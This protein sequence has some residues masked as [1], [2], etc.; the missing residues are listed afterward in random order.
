MLIIYGIMHIFGV[1]I[2][3]RHRGLHIFRIF[4]LNFNFT[5]VSDFSG[6]ESSYEALRTSIFICISRSRPMSSEECFDRLVL[7]FFV[8]SFT[9]FSAIRDLL[10]ALG[11]GN[12]LS[13]SETK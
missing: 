12:L 11:L 3:F 8:K 7:F 6:G 2:L 4:L 9:T 1:A 13:L 5:K 10:S